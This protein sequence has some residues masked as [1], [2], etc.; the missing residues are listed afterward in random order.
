MLTYDRSAEPFGEPIDGH[1]R[2][3]EWSDGDRA[4]LGVPLRIRVPGSHRNYVG[5]WWAVNGAQAAQEFLAVLISCTSDAPAVQWLSPFA[6]LDSLGIVQAFNQAY[7]DLI[8]KNRTVCLTDQYSDDVPY[9]WVVGTAVIVFP[10]GCP[11]RTGALYLV[12]GCASDS[13]WLTGK[14]S[15]CAQVSARVCP[16][17]FRHEHNDLVPL[18]STP[19]G[20]HPTER[21]FVRADQD[22]QSKVCC[23]A[24]LCCLL[25]RMLQA[26]Q[27][28]EL[29]AG[30]GVSTKAEE[31]VVLG[32]GCQHQAGDI[33]QIAIQTLS[34]LDT[35]SA[36]THWIVHQDEDDLKWGGFVRVLSV[37]VSANGGGLRVECQDGVSTAA[38][39]RSLAAAA[40]VGKG[41]LRQQVWWTSQIYFRPISCLKRRVYILPQKCFAAYV[42]NPERT[43]VFVHSDAGFDWDNQRVVPFKQLVGGCRD[44]GVQEPVSISMLLARHKMAIGHSAGRQTS[45]WRSTTFR[46]TGA[47]AALLLVMSLL[48]LTAQPQP[49]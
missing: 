46:D 43:D 45:I 35:L 29:K 6:V 14:S 5:S 27:V 11:I 25:S 10:D 24:W 26:H 38:V 17:Y 28:W 15:R 4:L 23:C 34:G 8:V 40:L 7:P 32:E 30:R 33:T 16:A 1:Y 3:L 44:A 31:C 49:D 13:V 42:N 47:A 12:A 19:I 22:A 20:V 48:L 18:R 9:S 41:E 36:G 37:S 39:R 21:A 2:G